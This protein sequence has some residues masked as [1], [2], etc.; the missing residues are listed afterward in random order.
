MAE[1]SFDVSAARQEQADGVRM[2]LGRRPVQRGLAVPLLARVHPRAGSRS[3]CSTSARPVRAAVIRIVSPSGSTALTSAPAS[4]SPLTIGAL[5]FT[6]ASCSG[7][8]P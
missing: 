2:I 1:R 6:A 8:T 5:P 7:V 4:M 3:A